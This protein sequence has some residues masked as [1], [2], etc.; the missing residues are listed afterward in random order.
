M[1]KNI[2]HKGFDGLVISEYG[3]HLTEFFFASLDHIWI[4]VLR[5]NVIFFIDQRKRVW[6][7]L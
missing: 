3:L 5:H 7:E 4:G 1:V 6:I 2:I